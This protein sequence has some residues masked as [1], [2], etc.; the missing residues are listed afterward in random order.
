MNRKSL[1]FLGIFL[2]VLICASSIALA[3]AGGKKDP[4]PS[5]NFIVEIEGITTS[6]FVYVEGIG[7]DLEVVEYRLG[8]EKNEV[9]LVPGLARAGPLT[10]KRYL[11]DNDELW[12]W[13]KATRDNAVSRKSMSVIITDRNREEQVR[14]NF[15]ECWPSEYYLEPLESKPSDVALEV[16]VIQYESM[17]RA[18]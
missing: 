16:I 11:D 1:F 5:S 10:L 2:V 7:S 6:S 15:H 12:K 9:H 13:F 14:Y 8:S 18:E 3:P 4:L 17:E